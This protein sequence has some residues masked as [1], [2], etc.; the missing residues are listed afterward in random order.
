MNA[1]M[2]A[3]MNECMHASP[4][5]AKGA[6]A[7]ARTA[8]SGQ[9]SSRDRGRARVS[10]A[11]RRGVRSA[12]ST[13]GGGPRGRRPPRGAPRTSAGL[14]PCSTGPRMR[15]PRPHSRLP[16]PPAPPWHRRPGAGG[17]KGVSNR[18]PARVPGPRT[19]LPGSGSAARGAGPR[20]PPTAGRR[21]P[22][23]PAP[24]SRKPEAGAAAFYGSRGACRKAHPASGRACR[25]TARAR[26]AALRRDLRVAGGRLPEAVSPPRVFAPLW[27]CAPA[28]R[29]RAMARPAQRACRAGASP[30]P[31]SERCG[32][33][34]GRAARRVL[35]RAVGTG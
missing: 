22:A 8:G 11:D 33:R 20:R 14:C 21:L 16:P 34:Q 13:P 1:R 9:A 2:N 6:A 3:R 30:A 23:P 17:G 25:G 15:C 10:S 35:L 4:R 24:Q 26:S 29:P 19:R 32:R 31:C 27:P 12:G 18:H 28:G 7:G 5:S